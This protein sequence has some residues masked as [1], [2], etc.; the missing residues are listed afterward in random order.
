MVLIGLVY[1]PMAIV[2]AIVS[3][4]GL[5]CVSTDAQRVA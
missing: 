5:G 4:C 3:E 1:W 2:I